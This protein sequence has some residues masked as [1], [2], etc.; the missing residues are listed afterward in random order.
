MTPYFA[1]SRI[2]ACGHGSSWHLRAVESCGHVDRRG[3]QCECTKFV[4]ARNIVGI[5]LA[6]VETR[7]T[8]FASFFGMRAETKVLFLD[9]AIIEA[10]VTNNPAIVSIDAPLSKPL[11]GK[12]RECEKQL[13]KMGIR[14][15]PCLFTQMAKLTERGIKLAKVLTEKGYK[16]I[17]SYPGAA[18]DILGLP[19]KGKN[20]LALQKALVEYGVRGITKEGITDHELD[21]VTSA[22]VGQLYLLGKAKAIGDCSEGLMVIPMWTGFKH[23]KHH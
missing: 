12:M 22:I 7:E 20:P 23:G 9:E 8:G 21:A 1:V 11:Q 4:A 5:D 19:R 15:F 16:V 18:Q 2:C 6:G 10:T 3:K 17:E 13:V 14:V